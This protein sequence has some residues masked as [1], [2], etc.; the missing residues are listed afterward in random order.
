MLIVQECDPRLN[1]ASPVLVTLE[2]HTF[3]RRSL[4]RFDREKKP[5]REKHP[6]MSRKPYYQE[7]ASAIHVVEIHH[8]TEKF[9]QQPPRPGALRKSPIRPFALQLAA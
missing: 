4:E 3:Q 8:W 7:H 1:G 9:L 5:S 2:L 6:R